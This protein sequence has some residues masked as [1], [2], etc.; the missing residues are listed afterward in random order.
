MKFLIIDDSQDF[1]SIVKQIFSGRD[2]VFCVECHSVK[3]ALDAIDARQP[4]VMFLDHQLGEEGNEGIE[5]IDKIKDR[6]I[7]VYST[8]TNAREEYEERRIEVINKWDL[9]RF[10]LII[11]ESCRKELV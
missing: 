3:E 8:T 5:I 6:G 7:K 10:N 2:D 11:N 1:I 4:D 9:K